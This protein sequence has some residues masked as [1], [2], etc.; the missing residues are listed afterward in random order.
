MLDKTRCGYIAIVGRPNVGKSTLL[1]DFLGQKLSITSRKPQTT[2]YQ[3]VGIKTTDT[4]QAIFVDTP[5]LHKNVK[6]IMNRYMNRAASSSLSEV[7]V[8]IFIVDAARWAADDQWILEK[9][10]SVKTPV[11]L[12]LNKIDKIKDKE[13][14]LQNLQM[15]SSQMAFTDIVPISAK[16]GHNVST[17]EVLVERL[18]PERDFLYPADQLTD[19]SERFLAAE[20]IREKVMRFTSQEL[21]YAIAVEIEEFKLKNNILH[22]GAVIWVEK[23][24]QKTIII[25]KHGEQLKTIGTEARLEMERLFE[26]KIFLRLWVKVKKGWTSDER[27]LHSLGLE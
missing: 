3:I 6:A 9:L 17:L 20:F 4:I 19:R 21:P 16:T 23:V 10:Q 1:N 27:A 13:I 7:D 5:G 14:L 2:R 18:L 26:Q 15:M 8:I 22:I 11:I 12:V 25:G 24:G